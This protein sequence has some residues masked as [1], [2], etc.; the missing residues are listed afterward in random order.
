MITRSVN[1]REVIRML[2]RVKAEANQWVRQLG[3]D[4]KFALSQLARFLLG[5]VKLPRFIWHQVRRRE[6]RKEVV[7]AALFL[8]VL[9]LAWAALLV[10]KDGWAAAIF[11][12][13]S[14]WLLPAWLA[15]AVVAG[16][17]GVDQRGFRLVAM[18]TTAGMATQIVLDSSNTAQ[19][20]LHTCVAM[21]M[22]VLGAM[23]YFWLA[24]LEAASMIRLV[25]ALS[26]GMYLLLLAQPPSHGTRAWL[27]IGGSSFQLTEA[28]RLL[29][30]IAAVRAATDREQP[31]REKTMTVFKIL[32][33]HSMGLALCNEFGT[34]AL[35]WINCIL[36]LFL[37]V[38]Q[39]RWAGIGLGFAGL[40]LYLL[41]GFL[42]VLAV[43][44]V[45]VLVGSG[46]NARGFGKVTAVFGSL[47]NHI[48]G[49]FGDIL[50][51]SRLMALMLAGSVIAQV[52]NTL[53]AIPGNIV[54]FILISA[55]GNALNFALNLLGCYVHDLR[56]QCLEYFNKFYEDGGK[57][58]RPL[59]LSGKYYDI[60]A[61]D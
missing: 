7:H 54:I 33:L 35:I 51:Y 2:E 3:S 41:R 29:A 50:S 20:I 15:A 31:D 9:H 25:N 36:V 52:F 1:E 21:V 10:W 46:W 47:Y 30:M 48:T 55:A 60:D 26:V 45:M 49:Y 44:G 32:A 4:L 8:V 38:H 27:T 53:G 28:E 6:I 39:L 37:S 19:L 59:D 42:P 57:P 5:G 22:A 34:L 16:V 17:F 43:G 13:A 14:R 18:L 58:F 24:S 12:V 40:A 61:V 23:S 11:L 56:L